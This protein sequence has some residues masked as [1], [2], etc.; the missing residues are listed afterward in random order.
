[1]NKRT[2]KLF[3]MMKWIIGN[4]KILKR[5]MLSVIILTGMFC[6]GFGQTPWSGVYG[7]EWLAG[8]YGQEW[9]KINVKN[10]AIYKITLPSNFQN[11]AAFLHLYHRGKEVSL[12]NA[13][14]TEIQ[15]Y[16]IPNDGKSDELLFYSSANEPDTTARINT[17]FSLYSDE[18]SYFLTYSTSAGERALIID[19]SITNIPAETYHVKEEI[20]QYTDD[21]NY[22]LNETFSTPQLTSSFWISG[23]GITGKMYG[24]HS[25]LTNPKLLG[26]LRI[27]LSVKNLYSGADWH[28]TLEVLLYGRRNDFN[29]D[30]TVKVGK[31]TNNL[32]DLTSSGHL[33]F[34]ALESKKKEFLLNASVDTLNSDLRNNGFL[35]VAF[36]TNNIGTGSDYNNTGVFSLSYVKLRYS[37]LFSMN[38]QSTASFELRA[39]SDTLS[40]VV[41]P[42]AP[43]NAKVFDVTDVHKPRILKSYIVNSELNIMVSRKVN[44]SLTLLVTDD[45]PVD[46]SSNATTVSFAEISPS[47][48][49][50][51]IVTTDNL[52]SAAEEY[53][54]Y[55]GSSLG[56]YMRPLVKEIKEIYNQFNYGEPSPVAIKRFADYMLSGGIRDNHNLLLIGNSV[57]IGDSIPKNKELPDQ[58]PTFGY[59]ASDVLLVSGLAGV[60]N[61]LPAIPVGRIGASSPQ[62]VLD[63]LAKVIEYE[64]DT[65]SREWRKNVL[66]LTGGYKSFQR[67]NMKS[68]MNTQASKITSTPFSG[69]VTAKWKQDADIKSSTSEPVD[70][71][72]EVNTGV[73]FISYYGHGYPGYTEL[74]IGNVSD[75]GRGYVASKKYSVMSFAACGVGNIFNN[76]N[77][78]LARDWL[79]TPNKGAIAIIGLSTYGW[80][81]VETNN[82][83]KLYEHIFETS[84]EAR[85]TIGAILQ[86]VGEDLYTAPNIYNPYEYLYNTSNAI[87]QRILIGDPALQILR[88]S[89]QC[90]PNLNVNGAVTAG[91]N[92]HK[93]A[94]NFLVVT[95]TINS[96]AEANY[97]AGTEVVLATGFDALS[98]SVFR[99]YV[100][101]C[102][103]SDSSSARKGVE[104]LATASEESPSEP[105]LSVFPNPSN[106]L[107][108][109]GLKNIPT[110]TVEVF[111]TEGYKYV[112]ESFYGQRE[113][114]VN[115][116][117]EKPG[118]YVIRVVSGNKVYTKTIVKF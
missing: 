25:T 57:T 114:D 30:I 40:K 4:E 117:K 27:K 67:D 64:Q 18:S 3:E 91:A 6:E 36:L 89:A 93:Q 59:P 58:V 33:L 43:A 94:Q 11:K 65:S 10:K 102:S 41:I 20:Q 97:H 74:N 68:F 49:D 46:L 21:Y 61:D 107:I 70:I 38:G 116:K 112:S 63:Y 111:G 118:L 9:L 14:A 12:L 86:K 55:R 56:G 81:H 73:G 75:V 48:Y 66:H 26:D 53:K 84:E 29:N 47:A 115:I 51:L 83:P 92:D 45:S 72:S 90:K 15:F 24:R 98:G 54:S 78:T 42:G 28:P 80:E 108:K 23:K 16:G 7:N 79:L 44:K 62:Q 52:K 85:G 13:T 2:I 60:Q 76:R 109:I 8:K 82:I 88:N 95:N 100:E 5:L 31:D 104:E 106:G 39:T 17:N 110:G 22:S 103:G 105:T 35:D 87:H 99:G 32:R 113:V 77:N 71:S 37:Q 1:M 69:S 50:Y 19:K 96:G 34:N 101:P